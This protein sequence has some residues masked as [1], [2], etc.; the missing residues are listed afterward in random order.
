MFDFAL[1]FLPKYFSITPKD[2]I[3]D[4]YT[5]KNFINYDR[6]RKG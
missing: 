4:T 2:M 1:K 5:L 6:Y 3:F